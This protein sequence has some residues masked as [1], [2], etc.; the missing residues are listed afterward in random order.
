MAMTNSQQTNL[1]WIIF[2]AALGMLF[3]MVSVDLVTVHGWSE[4]F[5]PEFVGTTLGHIGAVIAA[6]VGGKL[7][8][9]DND[10]TGMMTRASDPKPPTLPPAA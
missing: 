2:V 8:P 10:R 1:G 7:I 6:F 3:S 5:T 9:Q 4:L